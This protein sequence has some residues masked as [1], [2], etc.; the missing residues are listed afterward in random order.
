MLAQGGTAVGTGLNAF[1]GF[2][3]LVASEIAKITQLPFCTATN[4]VY[5][6]LRA[7]TN[8]VCSLRH[9]QATIQ[10]LR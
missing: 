4:K 5:F 10:W 7:C 2:D 3:E 6:V 8:L 9:W 1:V